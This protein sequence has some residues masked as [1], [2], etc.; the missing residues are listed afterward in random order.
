MAFFTILIF[1][2]VITIG[3][4]IADLDG[5]LTTFLGSKTLKKF[6][7]P[8]TKKVGSDPMLFSSIFDIF[9][10]EEPN[11]KTLLASAKKEEFMSQKVVSGEILVKFK[12]RGQGSALESKLKNNIELPTTLNISS[13]DK[14]NKK[15]KVKN[16]TPVLQVLKSQSI[17]E[18]K[19]YSQLLKESRQDFLK[20]TQKELSEE[21]I[22]N[23]LNIYLIKFSDPKLDPFKSAAEYSQDPNIEYAEPNFVY[24]INQTVPNDPYYSSSGSWGQNYDDLWGLKKIQAEKAWGITTGS[25]DIVVAITDTGIDYNHPDLQGQLWS[26]KD[27]IPNNGLDDDNNGYIDDVKGWD[28]TNSDN[29]PMDDHGHG[30]HVAGTINALTNNAEGIAGIS[31]DSKVMPLK[32]LTR[33]G[34]G[35]TS[36]LANAINYAVFEGADAI[37]MSWGGLGESQVIKEALTSAY[38]SGVVLVA[39]AGNGYGTDVEIIYPAKD[40]HVITVAS[41][42]HNDL[43][44]DFSSIGVKVD[45]AAPGGDS[46]YSGPPDPY[47]NILSLRAS[48]TDMYCSPSEGCNTMVV[49]NQY[50]RARGT[51]MATPHVAGVA[52]LILAKHPDWSPEEV[53]QAI[54]F[55]A[56]DIMKL[57]WDRESGYG[58]LNAFQSL[59]LNNVCIAKISSPEPYA[60]IGQTQNLNVI[61]SASCRDSFQSY[62]IDIGVGNEPQKWNTFY[63]SS[64]PISESNLATLNLTALSSDTFEFTVRLTVEDMDGH[65]FQDRVLIRKLLIKQGWPRTFDS[66]A[67]PL[68]GLTL[69]PLLTLKNQQL[70]VHMNEYPPDASTIGKLYVIGADAKDAP[71][72]PRSITAQGTPL[73]I[74]EEGTVSIGELD[75]QYPGLELAT[76]SLSSPPVYNIHLFHSDGTEIT[77][78]WPKNVGRLDFDNFTLDYAILLADVDLDG[79]MEIISQ[80]ED[81]IKIWAQDGTLIFQRLDTPLAGIPVIAN[82]DNDIFP[83]IV[84]AEGDCIHAFNFD[85]SEVIGWP[86]CISGAG[87][88]WPIQLVAADFEN[89]G[90]HEI[91]V[92]IQDRSSMLKVFNSDGNLD[93]EYPIGSIKWAPS[94]PAI[95]DINNDNELEIIVATDHEVY[96]FREDGTVSP[97][98]PVSTPGFMFQAPVTADIDGDGKQEIFIVQA[99]GSTLF[100]WKFDGQPLLRGVSFP[101]SWLY[102]ATPA[103]GDMDQNG[104]VDLVAAGYWPAYTTAIEFPFSISLLVAD[105]PMFRQGPQHLGV[106]PPLDSDKD[107]F[108][109]FSENYFG[110]DPFDACPDNAL[111]PAW[112]SDINNDTKIDIFDVLLYK[113]KLLPNPYDKRYDL[114]TDGEVDIS[115]VLLFKPLLGKSCTNP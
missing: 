70:I 114:N 101:F 110:T 12:T 52:A 105:W 83:E 76:L 47:N 34:W 108:S 107:G 71:N 2:V 3:F 86:I 90:K 27:E 104:K 37:N 112:P 26:N 49:D 79:K 46:G 25:E 66:H 115:D 5:E 100:G 44:S 23:L 74:L 40:P 33:E 42:D 38:V 4:I 51:S 85:E 84:F 54:R 48:G 91:V 87:Q 20:A 94:F 67:G 56:D 13:L 7:K 106:F 77:N 82:M 1:L 73:N 72:W 65:K 61:G 60:F 29:D 109:D 35:Y 88:R 57:G 92:N 96:V 16:I 97:G 63:S 78:G 62:V 99:I 41:S 89:D 95:A 17:R 59:T 93:W 55:G 68:T 28:F 81:G 58:R 6:E 43:I 75:S 31:W 69:T 14:L 53:R 39:A 103:L 9:G 50:Y 8:I 15:Y 32:G 98:W 18:N 111:D 64:I 80:V 10:G 102:A 11:L 22:P 30:T 19:S 24:K 21:D 45:V 113:P 36:W